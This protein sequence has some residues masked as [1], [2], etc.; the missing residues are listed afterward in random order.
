MEQIPKTIGHYKLEEE[1]SR[2]TFS[3]V[4]RG[5]HTL[6]KSYVAIKIYNRKESNSE[7]ICHEVEILKKLDHPFIAQFFEFLE[8]DSNYYI[9][10][11]YVE[12]G[13]LLNF[14]NTHENT[15]EEIGRHY[16]CQLV[17]ALDYL[18]NS[19]LI[20]HRD[21]KPENVLIDRNNNIR[22]IDFG[23]SFEYNRMNPTSNEACGSTAYSS[24]EMIKGNKYD[25]L[26]DIWSLG[27]LLYAIIIGELPF[28][29]NNAQMLMRK[30]IFTDP[31]YPSRVSQQLR[32][33][34]RRLFQK[35]P[36]N[37]ISLDNIKIH[38][39]VIISKHKHVM[40]KDIGAEYGHRIFVEK[41]K[42]DATQSS[43]S[44]N[45][46]RRKSIPI[47]MSI[48][49][50]QFINV[51]IPTRNSSSPVEI[52]FSPS[53]DQSPIA[54][55]IWEHAS[56]D[57]DQEEIDTVE[58][59]NDDLETNEEYQ[60]LIHQH[61]N[62]PVIS[63]GLSSNQEENDKNDQNDKEKFIFDKQVLKIIKEYQINIENLLKDLENGVIN[64]KTALYKLLKKEKITDDIVSILTQEQK[65]TKEGGKRDASSPSSSVKFQLKFSPQMRSEDD[66]NLKPEVRKKI[67]M[68]RKH[69][70]DATREASH[71]R[72]TISSFLPRHLRPYISNVSQNQKY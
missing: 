11:E 10:M 44:K 3:T 71:T 28:E 67:H 39:W 51:A 26:T 72:H 15:P 27:V 38:P 14:I 49:M 68:K 45:G 55:P 43:P 18:H 12:N 9:I 69:L 48:N 50:H 8:D 63:E 5:Q 47:E 64:D 58:I 57:L 42:K 22:L 56:F 59:S 65:L 2:G 30:I 66:M 23:N 19:K 13:S 41:Y 1:I 7:A 24:P 32:D 34:F 36:E 29:D 46:P 17:C 54:S 61:D 53:S 37:R 6:T 52:D 25:S 16:F 70:R 21:I 33:L 35:R 20:I 60:E 31:K 40:D 62:E 4:W